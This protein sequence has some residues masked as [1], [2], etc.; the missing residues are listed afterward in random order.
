M[1]LV[2]NLIKDV[3]KELKSATF[4][5]LFTISSFRVQ[6]INNGDRNPAGDIP[7]F[8]FLEFVIVLYFI[9][10]VILVFNFFQSNHKT[11]NIS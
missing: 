6:F 3:E 5:L 10:G 2:A 8:L 1:I 7:L 9:F 11:S 4:L